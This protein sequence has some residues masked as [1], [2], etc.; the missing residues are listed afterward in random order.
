MRRL[1]HSPAPAELKELHASLAAA[2]RRLEISL[3]LKKLNAAQLTPTARGL[4]AW[5]AFVA[6]EQNFR[7]YVDAAAR[8]RA[9]LEPLL[10]AQSR[11][12]PPVRIYLKP[13]R[14]MYHA[15]QQRDGLEMSVPTAAV[16]FGDAD[17]LALARTFLD[18]DR[19]AKRRVLDTMQSDDFQAI[20]AEL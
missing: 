15:R 19:L 12:K 10:A 8:G 3:S 6:D 2:T 1:A 4:R 9:I 13:L 11:W 16:C 17:W 7:A 14:G 18:G 5:L 20:A